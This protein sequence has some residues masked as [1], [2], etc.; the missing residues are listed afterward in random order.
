[1]KKITIIGGGATGTLLAVN[2]I[3]HSENG[4]PI[5]I[6]LVDESERFGR[7]VAYS[8]T[9]DFHLL[10]VPAAKM[11]AFPDDIEHFHRWTTEKN[12][13]F[14]PNDFAPRRVYGEYLRDLLRRTIENKTENIAVS[15]FD[16]EAVDVST[17]GDGSQVF[18][19]SGKSIP[20]DKIVLAFGNFL[21]PHP[22]SR[23][24]EFVRAEKYF[25]NPWNHARL[26]RLKPT[27]E[28]FIIGTGLTAIDVILTLHHRNHTGKIH[29]FSTRGLLPAVHK[30]G[31]SYPSFYDEL[32]SKKRITDLLKIVR[33][34]IEK[35]HANGGDWRA[36]IDSLRPHTQSIWRDL[37]DA[38]KR[39]FLQ[40][41]SRYWN[42]AR[43][44]VPPE[45]MRILDEMQS[46][47]Q[48]QI[49]KGRL[50]NI[51]TNDEE[52][53]IYMTAN[54]ESKSLRADAIVNCIGSE[55]NFNRL[56]VPL[57]KN[58]IGKNLIK[59]DSLNFGIDATP[60]GK[61]IDA[62]GNVSE[63]IRTVGTALKGVLWESTAMPEIRKQTNDL[64]L[65]LLN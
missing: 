20:T 53:A 10:N 47:N 25:Q 19:K 24:K 52:F 22:R 60:D 44:R 21:P 11:G 55:S 61:T 31:F 16:D 49:L 34:H 58:L 1:M 7:G 63:D 15:V 17:N 46:K 30:L 32:K 54:G 12:Y 40:H 27:D 14:A 36:V 2:L 37:P 4:A 28:I 8:T 18:L 6:N 51:E 42:V 62:D 33:R 38:E 56:D 39:Y 45:A 43:H 65:S 29:A 41:L 5:R 48:L 57:V 9:N 64:A 23:D 13:D 59:T 3:K 26:E 50:K 35:A